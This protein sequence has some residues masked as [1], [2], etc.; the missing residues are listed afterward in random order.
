MGLFQS[1]QVRNSNGIVWYSGGTVHRK[2][3]PAVEYSNGNQ[4]W[5]DHG[6][7]HRKN[8]PAIIWEYDIQWWWRGLQHRENGPALERKNGDKEWYIHGKLHREDGPAID[9]PSGSINGTDYCGRQIYYLHGK[10]VSKKDVINYTIQKIIGICLALA[11]LRLDSES[12]S[13]IIDYAVST[14]MITRYTKMKII[15]SVCD[16][17]LVTRR[18]KKLKKKNTK[19]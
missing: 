17:Y 14:R 6:Q 12:L 2:N 8:G 15:G 5:Y 9:S 11:P 16:R 1:R 19:S 10:K 4:T 3:G 7:L 18:R 13:T